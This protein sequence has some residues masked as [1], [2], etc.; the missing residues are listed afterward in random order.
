MD[1]SVAFYR[2]VLGLKPTFTSPFW[3]E[4][5][6]GNGKLGLHPQLEGQVAPLGIYG[7]GWVLG[8][9]TDDIVALRQK[10]SEE[11]VTIHGDY[12]DVPGG[13]VLDFEDPDGNTIEAYQARKLT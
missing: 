13:V 1:R 7:K 3:S 8:V 4:F 6:L 5:D 11:G 12:H 2:D 10:L 9:A